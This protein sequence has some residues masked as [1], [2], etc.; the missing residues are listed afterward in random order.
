MRVV[1]VPSGMITVTV[2]WSKTYNRREESGL[3][4]SLDFAGKVVVILAYCIQ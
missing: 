2:G 4:F 3:Y 1:A